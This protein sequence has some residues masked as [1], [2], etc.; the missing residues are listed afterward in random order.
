MVWFQF[1][2]YNADTSQARA[3]TVNVARFSV[4]WFPFFS[5]HA[6]SCQ[7]RARTVNA[8]RFS[9]VWFPFFSGHADT[10]QAHAS[11]GNAARFF[12]WSGFRSFLGMRTGHVS[13]TYK[14]WKCRAIFNGLV[15]D[16]FPPCAHQSITCTGWKCRAIFQR[17]GFRYFPAMRT[18]A[19]CQTRARTGNAA[20]FS[21]VWFPLFSRHVA[22]HVHGT[23]MQRDLLQ[24]FFQYSHLHAESTS[25]FPDQQCR[26]IFFCQVPTSYAL[27]PPNNH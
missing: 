17:S 7:A 23:Q 1:F 19:A 4:V 26:T 2:S 5:R 8:A 6:D 20:R 10:C 22:S 21:M 15:S 9:V 25:T 13:S 3:R 11:I 14:D 16:L 27:F 24:S 18:R 12:Q